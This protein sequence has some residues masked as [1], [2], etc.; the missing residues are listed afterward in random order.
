MHCPWTRTPSSQGH[1]PDEF[2]YVAL[3]ERGGVGDGDRPRAVSVGGEGDVTSRGKSGGLLGLFCLVLWWWLHSCLS[4]LTDLHSSRGDFFLPVDSLEESAPSEPKFRRS[5]VLGHVTKP[6]AWA[7][8]L[9][10]PMESSFGYLGHDT[11]SSGCCR[12]C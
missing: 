1:V 8:H 11:T 9:A 5:S 3:L 6:P 12:R 10:K 7:L 2:T 4:K